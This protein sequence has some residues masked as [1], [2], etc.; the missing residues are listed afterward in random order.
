M[1][2]GRR[3]DRALIAALCAGA[4][5][6]RSGALVVCGEAGVGKTALLQDAAEQARDLYVLRGAGVEAEVELAFAALH[7]LLRPVLDRLEY[8]PGPQASALRGAFGLAETRSSPLLVELATLGLLAEVAKDQPLLCLLDDAQWLDQASADALAFVAR[9][10]RAAPIVL[11][12]ASRDG[13]VRQ[14][15]APG[16]PQLRLTGLDPQAAGRLLEE[17]TDSIAADVRDRLIAQTE[18]NPLAL[19]KLS[20]TLSRAQLTG[21]EPLPDRPVLSTRLQQAFLRQ[22]RRLPAATRTL[23]LV[24]AA[25]DAGELATVLTAG[26]ALGVGPDALEPAERSGVVQV[27]NLELRFRHRLIRSAIYHSVTSTS[28][29]AVHRALA[30]VLAGEQHADRR[31]WHLAA[32]AVGP[33]ERVAAALEDSARRAR[34]RGEPAVAA[35][36]LERAAVLTPEMHACGRRL[37]AA[38]R[39]AWE[40]GH[41]ERAQALLELAA[42]L[43][44]DSA[45]R[46]GIAHVRGAIELGAGTPSVACTTLVQGAE[47]ILRTAPEQAAQMLVL[48]TRA[49]VSA[50]KLER[51]VDEIGPAILRL[52]GQDGAR[53][54]PLADSLIRVARG[55]LTKIP[56]AIEAGPPRASAT[57]VAS[58]EDPRLWPWPTLVVAELAGNDLAAYQLCARSVAIHRAAGTVGILTLALANLAHAEVALGRWSAAIDTAT[59]GLRL[60]EETGQHATAAQL[61]ATLAHVAALQGRA[62]AAR[63]LADEARARALPRRIALVAAS[64]SWTVAVLDLA[65]GRPLAAFDRLL[66]LMTHQHP[67][68]HAVIAR[69]AAADL[70]E[71]AART[72]SLPGMEAF[73]VRL[74]QWARWDR[75]PLPRVLE[76]RSRALVSKGERAERHYQAALAVDGIGDLP[77]ELARTELLYG[78]WLRRMRRQADARTHLS[79]AMELLER[80]GAVFWLERARSELRASGKRPR[81]RNFSELFQLTPQE[82]HVAQLA[83]RGLTNQEI[84]ARLVLSPHTVRDHLHKI[85]RKLEIVSRADLREL[86]LEGGVAQ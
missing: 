84:A 35:A 65:T 4:R 54:R 18:G 70:I 50:S 3:E 31:A 41:S 10:L 64:A 62:D 77:F 69:L 13:D 86:D 16:L 55:H 6:G 80:L 9:R 49:A 72:D 74:G 57:W 39:D 2:Y 59:E 19:L 40:A 81:R 34:R 7:Q 45:A 5:E 63:R 56:D 60:A 11:L 52:P 58:D 29:R 61:L 23:L 76:H 73:T 17:R 78:E 71:A 38:A 26:Q 43:A 67:I 25:E 82:L 42:P 33:D 21:R 8:L 24:A 85:F 46:A 20:A 48:A 44:T 32:A 53:L 1:L 37:V 15:D 68:T 75:R 28:R 51:I 83:A 36:A 22:V 30:E 66:S 27:G 79:A 12:L 14:L 47:L